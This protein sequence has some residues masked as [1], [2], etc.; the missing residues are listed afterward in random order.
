MPSRRTRDG[1]SDRPRGERNVP[2][3]RASDSHPD[4]RSVGQFRRG[5]RSGGRERARIREGVHPDRERRSGDEPAS[6]SERH[7]VTNWECRLGGR[8]LRS[9]LYHIVRGNFGQRSFDHPRSCKDTRCT[10][11]HWRKGTGPA[12]RQTSEQEGEPLNDPRVLGPRVW[13]ASANQVNILLTELLSCSRTFAETLADAFHLD[14]RTKRIIR[15]A[16]SWEEVKGILNEQG[17][18]GIEEVTGHRGQFWEIVQHII[19]Q[20]A[21]DVG[22][23]LEVDLRAVL[24][25][26]Q[27][28]QRH[29]EQRRH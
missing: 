6:K 28:V 17:V 9:G 7:A 19:D 26:R 5:R 27:W 29:H 21:E 11:Q 18:L 22:P 2:D 8:R 16:R 1:R 23:D 10:R 4:R 3:R 12:Y 13:Q 25:T 20:E 15:K 14:R 24:R